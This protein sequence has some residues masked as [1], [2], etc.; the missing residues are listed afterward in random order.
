VFLLSADPE[1][2]TRYALCFSA[3]NGAQLWSREYPSSPHKLHVRS[4]YASSTPAVDEQRVY[5]AWS[6]PDETTLLALTHDGNPVWKIDL[7][8]WVSQHGFG[9]SPVIYNDMVLLNN[10]QD[11]EEVKGV[12]TPGDSFF[13]AFNRHT[14]QELWRTPR[15]SASV[16]YSVP[17]IYTNP[18]GQQ[19]IVCLSTPEGV[20][21]LDPATGKQ[22]WCVPDSFTMRTVSSPVL[23]GGLIFGSTGSGGGGNYVTAVQ[24]G[25]NAHVAYNVRRQAPYVPTAVAKDDAVFLWSDIGVVTCI[26]AATGEVHYGERAHDGGFSGSTIL[27]GDKVYC[28]SDDGVLVSIAA[29]TK[30]LKVLGKTPLGEGSRSTPAVSGGRMFLRTYSHLICVGNKAS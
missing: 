16:S 17:C 30:A 4:S 22:N 9:T 21:G 10:S 29:D 5:F 11:G 3:K 26:A 24:P 19:E 2:A 6:S 7:G 13:M 28:I 14:G 18:Q 23:A 20:Y 15:G 27:A 25:N 12:E 1:T 8:R